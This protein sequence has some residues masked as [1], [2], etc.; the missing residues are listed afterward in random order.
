LQ[1]CADP[2]SQP[3]LRGRSAPVLR[4]RCAMRRQ[5]WADFHVHRGLLLV[6]VTT[7]F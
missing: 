7:R 5:V 4:V 3:D 6:A 2:R 1:L